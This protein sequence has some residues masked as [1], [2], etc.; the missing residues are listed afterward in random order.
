MPENKT[1][2]T[3]ASVAAF[4]NTIADPIRRK[5]TKTLATLLRRVTGEKPAMWG[6]SIVGFGEWSYTGSNGKSVAWFPVGLSPRKAALTLYLMGGL[7][8]H[9]D[10]LK[11]LGRHKVGGGCLYLPKLAEVDVQVLERIIKAN[12]ALARV[13]PKTPK[14]AT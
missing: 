5:D 4:L 2:R 10:L 11:Q 14:R 13:K 12:Q 3:R 7:K 6:T 8:P 9:A 1:Q